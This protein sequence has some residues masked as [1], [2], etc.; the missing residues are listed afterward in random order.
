[1]LNIDG[2]FCKEDSRKTFR[3]LFGGLESAVCSLIA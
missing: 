1:M 2:V 3:Y